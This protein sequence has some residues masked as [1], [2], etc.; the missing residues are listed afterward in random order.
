MPR[1]ARIFQDWKLIIP[2]LF[3]AATESEAYLSTVFWL[4]YLGSFFPTLLSGV[5]LFNS[6]F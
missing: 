4:H 3:C 1:E 6:D 2:Y 5:H